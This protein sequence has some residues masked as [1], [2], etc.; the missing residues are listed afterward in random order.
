MQLGHKNLFSDR[1]L[2]KT[3]CAKDGAI[4]QCNGFMSETN[5]F[6]SCNCSTTLFGAIRLNASQLEINYLVA[7]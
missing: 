1:L 2:W 6:K 4:W 3:Y 7:T 5:V